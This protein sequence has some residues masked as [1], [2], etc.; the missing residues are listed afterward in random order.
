[1]RLWFGEWNKA[2]KNFDARAAGCKS[3]AAALCRAARGRACEAQQVARCR[4][5]LKV[6]ELPHPDLYLIH[7]RFEAIGDEEAK[8][9][10]QGIATR[11]QLPRD[12][13]DLLVDWARRLLR[14]STRYQTLVRALQ[15]EAVRPLKP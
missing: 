1:M 11:L 10:L 3:F 2:A 9:K 13:V 8:R 4:E 7:V 6:H 14:G 12:Q 5:H 15:A